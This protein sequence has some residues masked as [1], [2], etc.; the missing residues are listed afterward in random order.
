MNHYTTVDAEGCSVV[1]PRYK[2]AEGM[3]SQV[4]AKHALMCS[5]QHPMLFVCCDS[6]HAPRFQ[7]DGAAA[8]SPLEPWE[9]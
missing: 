4:V 1:A 5:L 3:I 9:R 7:H 6:A 2:R 8:R